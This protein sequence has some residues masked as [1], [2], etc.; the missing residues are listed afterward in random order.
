VTGGFR[1][2]GTTRV[3]AA[4]FVAI[5][6]VDVE[7]DAGTFRRIVVRHPGAVVVVPVDASGAALCVR[8]WRVA[9][10]G[11]VL[12]VPA[13]KRDVDGEPPARTAA[14][15]L[16]EE[17]GVRAGTLVKLAEFWNTPGFCDEYSHLYLAL[18]LEET[19]ATAPTSPEE[20]AIVVERVALGDVERRIA[21]R[22]LVDAKSIIGLLLARAHLAGSHP[23]VAEVL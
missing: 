9:T 16:E 20:R 10:G 15:E 14:R 6:E 17:V 4:G 8:Q 3:A 2:R 1:V 12:E 11:P 7:S 13:G 23:G 18:D 5:D 19:G 21:R 22:E